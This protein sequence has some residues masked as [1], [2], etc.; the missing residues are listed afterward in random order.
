MRTTAT[1]SRSCSR[2]RS[3]SVRAMFALALTLLVALLAT[4]PTTVTAQLT[5]GSAK[6]TVRSS[7]M[8]FSNVDITQLKQDFTAQAAVVME[9]PAGSIVDVQVTADGTST[10]IVCRVDVSATI[11]PLDAYSKLKSS[12]ETVG[13]GL[14]ATGKVFRGFDAL[15]TVEVWCNS[16]YRLNNCDGA[17]ANTIDPNNPNDGSGSETLGIGSVGIICAIFFGL[18]TVTCFVWFIM[19]NPKHSIHDDVCKMHCFGVDDMENAGMRKTRN[20]HKDSK[21]A[22]KQ[23]LVA[24]PQ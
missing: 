13:E 11:V 4:T 8:L 7:D 24:P 10:K 3:R 19:C 1:H 15:S 17:V 14:L 22:E 18:I 23:R 12:L 21:R 2:S 16:E 20:D 6:I 9:I 5:Q